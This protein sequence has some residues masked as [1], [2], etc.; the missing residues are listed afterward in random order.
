MPTIR[1]PKGHTSDELMPGANEIEAGTAI[2]PLITLLSKPQQV[3]N[4]ERILQSVAGTPYEAAVKIAAQKWPRVLG[5]VN[6][7]NL[8]DLPTSVGGMFK[9]SS[10]ARMGKPI[11]D[12]QLANADSGLVSKLKQLFSG[13][14][15]ADT[16]GHELNHAAQALWKMPPEFLRQ[17]HD[18]DS[19]FGYMDNPFEVASRK[20][21]AKL[22]SLLGD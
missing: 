5:H 20:A 7:M 10:A 17:Y 9:P 4:V 8:T 21:G 13:N 11:G 15:P 3:A 16:V 22:R 18:A 12:I 14:D 1:L 19:V 2:A 6:S